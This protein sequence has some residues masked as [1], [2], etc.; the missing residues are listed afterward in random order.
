M[1]ISGF[2]SFAVDFSILAALFEFFELD[3]VVVDGNQSR[4]VILQDEGR[5]DDED[6]VYDGNRESDR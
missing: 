5:K 1:S 3:V 4:K 6:G 2:T